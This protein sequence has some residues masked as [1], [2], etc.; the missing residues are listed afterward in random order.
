MKRQ[1][2]S[3]ACILAS[4]AACT[5]TEAP[6]PSPVLR[7]LGVSRFDVVEA[8]T[9]LA[10]L[11]RDR[12][13]AVLASLELTTGR[14]YMEDDDRGDVDGRQLRIHAFG[15]TTS[16]ESAGYAPLNL[17][18]PR[19]ALIGAFLIEPA[20]A[21]KLSRWGIRIDPTSVP[22]G[23]PLAPAVKASS[24]DASAGY[25]APDGGYSSHSSSAYGASCVVSSY[26]GCDTSGFKKKM[27]RRS[28]SE[29]GEYRCCPDLLVFAER[30]CTTPMGLTS[31]GNA[32]PNGC[33]VCWS[34]PIAFP[35][36]FENPPCDVDVAPA[37]Y[38]V[39]SFCTR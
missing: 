31:C 11:A 10:V 32:G 17:P 37:G 26:G 1:I 38:C 13:G 27:F 14:F 19:E 9:R 30:A 12:S 22:A 34:T 7:E 16:H 4:S 33:A 18:F 15:K 39:A 25:C 35:V 20:V 21:A 3:V 23:E 6:G 36:G 8:D 29:W 2:L 28:A 5:E 24:F